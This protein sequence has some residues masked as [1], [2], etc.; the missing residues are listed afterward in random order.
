MHNT[1]K[2]GYWILFS[3]VVAALSSLALVKVL[4]DL[5]SM[6]QFG[7]VTLAITLVA[8]TS[9]ILIG[10]VNTGIGRYYSIAKDENDMHNFLHAV[11]VILSFLI[12]I[13]FLTAMVIIGYLT[14]SNSGLVLMALILLF[15]SIFNAISSVYSN[16]FNVARIRHIAS[17][18]VYLPPLL[19]VLSLLL[20]SLF[21]DLSSERVLMI[22]LVVSLLVAYKYFTSARRLALD[23]IDNKRGDYKKWKR[24]IVKYSL[25][26]LPWT[27]LI[28]VQQSSERWLLLVFSSL[29][30]V[31][32]YA[33][34]YMLGYTPILMLYAVLIK[35]LYPI[36]YERNKVVDNV[37]LDKNTD[38]LMLFRVISISIIFS[39][40]VFFISTMFHQEL[41]QL[42][43]SEKYLQYS[44]LLKWFVLSGSIFG[45]GELLLIKMQSNMKVKFLSVVKSYLGIFGFLLNLAGGY[46]AGF[47][48]I[49]TSMVLFSFINLF[50][51]IYANKK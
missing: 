15:L 31:G 24:N 27:F 26:F 46:L 20:L 28:W 1:V 16:I 44:Y 23:Y 17:I 43:V 30:E 8:F 36:L 33:V 35:F 32:V 34:L 12:C 45:I 6:E 41:F 48:G 9:Q 39:I 29:E 13:I 47:F 25:P 2:E 51:M 3:Q 11:K 19:K 14:L 42:F 18:N 4:S 22:Y 38:S 37:V 49:I 21:L 40:L 10:S 50:V 7:Q 5:I